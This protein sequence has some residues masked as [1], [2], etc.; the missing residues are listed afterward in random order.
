MHYARL[1]WATDRIL[2]ALQHFVDSRFIRLIGLHG[3][4]SV[5]KRIYGLL[6]EFASHGELIVHLKV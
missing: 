4:F 1:A 5:S 2:A 6:I 3:C